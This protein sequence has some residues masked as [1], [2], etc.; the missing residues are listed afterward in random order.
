MINSSGK[1]VIFSNNEEKYYKDGLLHN[2]V[3]KPAFISENCN[4]WFK[5]GILHRDNNKPAIMYIDDFSEM[6]EWYIKGDL[7]KNS[8]KDDNGDRVIDTWYRN[9]LLHRIDGPAVIKKF[10]NSI[11]YED[12]KIEKEWW[13]N[14]K[15]LND[16]NKF[17]LTEL[18]L[19]SDILGIIEKFK[20]ITEYIPICFKF[21]RSSYV[22][23]WIYNN[24][25]VRIEEYK[26]GVNSS[27][28]ENELEYRLSDA[29]MHIE[30]DDY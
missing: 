8:T 5:N 15:N 13:V 21:N 24:K 10:Y 26:E 12:E 2:E 18:N 25:I 28:I 6:C 23:K 29:Y 11:D 3:D 14:G 9:N 19:P 16:R 20:P 27:A 22:K 4:K 30:N 1:C 7:Q 17:E